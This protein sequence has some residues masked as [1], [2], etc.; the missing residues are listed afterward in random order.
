LRILLVIPIMF[1]KEDLLKINPEIPEDYD[2]KSTEFWSYVQDKLHTQREI[3]KLYF[4]S[5]TQADPQKALEFV[6][7]SNE[8]AAE[9]ILTLQKRGAELKATEDPLLLQETNSWSDM[10]GKEKDDDE[11]P[12]ATNELL[13]QSMVDRDKFVAGVINE[14]LKEGETGVLLLN[15]GR[16]VGDY[17]APDVRVIRVQRFDPNDYVN[18]WL[19]SLRF[20]SHPNS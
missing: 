7:K 5:L 12:S 16:N 3:K 11:S 14:S 2:E 10:V 9:L 1:S 4:D 13:M 15:P 19:V 17:I 8:Q 18:S 6:K 20:R